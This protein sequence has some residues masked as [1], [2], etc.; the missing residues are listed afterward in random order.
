MGFLSGNIGG[1]LTAEA[2]FLFY[3]QEKKYEIEFVKWP[4]KTLWDGGEKV[5]LS[6]DVCTTSGN[7]CPFYQWKFKDMTCDGIDKSTDP[8]VCNA[9]M[10]KYTG[11]KKERVYLCPKCSA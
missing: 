5:L 1:Y 10:N 4:G 7:N 9:V 11:D 3:K 8:N 2:S 6:C